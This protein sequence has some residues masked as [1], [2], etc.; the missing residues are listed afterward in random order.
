MGFSVSN[1]DENIIYTSHIIQNI[2]QLQSLF[3]VVID[4]FGKAHVA[5]FFFRIIRLV[6]TVIRRGRVVHS[7]LP[8]FRSPSLAEFHLIDIH[9]CK[10]ITELCKESMDPSDIWIVKLIVTLHVAFFRHEFCF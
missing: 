5:G 9:L 2:A 6:V 7:S 4:Q 8:F 3:P 1:V 10:V